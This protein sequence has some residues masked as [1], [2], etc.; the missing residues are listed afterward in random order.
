M[1]TSLVLLNSNTNIEREVSCRRRA[2]GL[3]IISVS[4][5]MPV[6]ATTESNQRSQLSGRWE[7][8]GLY[9]DVHALLCA[10]VMASL[11]AQQVNT[12]WEKWSVW[13][14]RGQRGQET[15]LILC[16]HALQGNTPPRHCRSLRLSV[17]VMR[18]LAQ[19]TI[20]WFLSGCSKP[21]LM[22]PSFASREF[23]SD[24]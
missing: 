19:A 3:S 2:L 10:A 18:H 23:V 24:S 7:V 22:I 21:R 20:F 12:Q 14:Q 1:K 6:V 11:T 13:P 16:S 8:S 15:M 4:Q 5:G 17:G 9:R